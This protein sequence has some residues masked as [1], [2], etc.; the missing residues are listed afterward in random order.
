[1]PGIFDEVAGLKIGSGGYPAN[2][3]C[4]REDFC[5]MTV[6]RK[7]GSKALTNRRLITYP[8]GTIH[9]SYHLWSFLKELTLENSSFRARHSHKGGNQM[10]QQ[11]LSM[12]VWNWGVN[13]TKITPK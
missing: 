9:T 8:Q 1:M 2:G 4:G 6:D 5:N 11:Y 13:A 7:F 3:K 10:L 12:N